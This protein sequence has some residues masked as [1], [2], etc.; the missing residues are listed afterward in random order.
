MPLKPLLYAATILAGG[1][2]AAQ[3]DVPMTNKSG[4]YANKET[5]TRESDLFDRIDLDNDGNVTQGELVDYHTSA[6]VHEP[7]D[8][9]DYVEEANIGEISKTF[10]LLD[11][12]K[13]GLL[14]RAEFV[15]ISEALE[16]STKRPVAYNVNYYVRL[17]RMDVDDLE[18]ETVGNLKGET[19]GA[20]EAIIE[21]KTSGKMYAMIDLDGSPKYRPGEMPPDHVG[22]KLTDMM[23]MEEQKTF[24]LTTKA[25]SEIRD[26]EQIEIDMDNFEEVD[27]FYTASR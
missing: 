10:G 8:E 18:G 21:N 11:E 22:I 24:A 6:V 3:A 12:N 2:T 13:N 26:L 25:E 19:I 23:F 15:G 4:L 7:V 17:T 5:P 20:I 9:Y 16:W 1:I 14:T 27:T